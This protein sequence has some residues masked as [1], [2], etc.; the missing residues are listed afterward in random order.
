[1][2]G[3]EEEVWIYIREAR[4][5][6]GMGAYHFGQGQVRNMKLGDRYFQFSIHF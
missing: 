3:K 5:G 4:G 6:V 1:M 2:L